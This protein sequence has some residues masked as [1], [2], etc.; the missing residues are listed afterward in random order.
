MTFWI[1]CS[2][3]RDASK[4]TPRRLKGT[5]KYLIWEPLCRQD[6]MRAS[7]LVFDN[8]LIYQQVIALNNCFAQLATLS[9]YASQP[10]LFQYFCHLGFWPS[11]GTLARLFHDQFGLAT[12]LGWSQG[13]CFHLGFC[14]PNRHGSNPVHYKFSSSNIPKGSYS[15]WQGTCLL[16]DCIWASVLF[17]SSR[18]HRVFDCQHCIH[19]RL[20]GSLRVLFLWPASQAWLIMYR[21]A[22][23]V[24]VY[25][26]M[27]CTSL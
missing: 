21:G 8:K 12:S 7:T 24:E 22:R 26:I 3:I 19:V 2:V 13:G 10:L 25:R 14:H 11:V 23:R 27:M 18:T 16:V 9:Q 1:P 15:S 17:V 5:Q 4:P 20:R 6:V